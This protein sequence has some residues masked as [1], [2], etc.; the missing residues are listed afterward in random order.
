M[1]SFWPTIQKF[2]PCASKN[3][4]PHV[5]T[6]IGMDIMSI[7]VMP[8]F[9]HPQFTYNIGENK[10]F[11]ES[12]L[13]NIPIADNSLSL[14]F[15][16]AGMSPGPHALSCPLPKKKSNFHFFWRKN[17]WFHLETLVFRDKHTIFFKITHFYSKLTFSFVKLDISSK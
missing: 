17:V 9:N 4:K 7:H 6:I 12:V 13:L 15:S 16:V 8:C 1:P 14:L 5:N 11:H 10:S 2:D 3:K